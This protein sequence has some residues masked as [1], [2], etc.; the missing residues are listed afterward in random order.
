MRCVLLLVMSCFV[1]APG[2]HAQEPLELRLEQ[3][4]EIGREGHSIRFCAH[5]ASDSRSRTVGLMFQERLPELGGMIF[6]FQKNDIVHMWMRN[7]ILPLDMVFI[8]AADRV[9]KIARNTTPFSLEIVS[10]DGPARYV[11]E[12]NAGAADRQGVE[13]GDKVML[14]KT[15]CSLP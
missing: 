9:T 1:L 15:K 7:T 10:S 13:I 5:A 3:A 8:D 12:I 6:D 14:S 4:V 11:L 2:A